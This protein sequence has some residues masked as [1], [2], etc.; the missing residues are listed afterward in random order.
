MV[1]TRSRSGFTAEHS[2][3][4]KAGHRVRAALCG[5]GSLGRSELEAA[6]SQSLD[7]PRPLLD[8]DP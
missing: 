5:H 6:G 4:E 8:V 2:W 3:D 1:Y 7:D